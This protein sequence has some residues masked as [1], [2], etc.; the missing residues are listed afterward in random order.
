MY[1]SAGLE[2]IVV[3]LSKGNFKLCMCV[4]YRP[5]SSPPAIFDNLCDV[6]LSVVQSHFSNFVLLGD[7]HWM[8]ILILLTVFILTFVTSWL[9]FHFRKLLTLQLIFLPMGDPL[10]LIWLL[11]LICILFLTACSVIPQ[12]SNSDHLGLTKT[13]TCGP[14]FYSVSQSLGVQ[15]RWLWQG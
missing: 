2:V 9:V 10:S 7:F 5:P 6:L 15:A 1:G 11:Y 8:L 3:S 4:F 14:Y 12:L 13:P